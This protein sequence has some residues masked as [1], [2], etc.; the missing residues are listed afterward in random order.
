MTALQYAELSNAYEILNEPSV[1]PPVQL[2]VKQSNSTPSNVKS[3]PQKMYKN[4]ETSI[5]STI[6]NFL[7]PK[8]YF[9][10]GDSS[11]QIISLLNDILMIL[12]IIM[13]VLVLL[14]LIKIL[15]KKN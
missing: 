2:K 11:Q 14:L 5:A 7:S 1:E 13:L 9:T 3:I 15:E 12:K 4:N 8:E 6:K 10:S